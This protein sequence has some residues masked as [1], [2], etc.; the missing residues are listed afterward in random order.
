[1]KSQELGVSKAL[2]EHYSKTVK[3][4]R[5]SRYLNIF[6]TLTFSRDFIDNLDMILLNF[7]GVSKKRLFSSLSFE[8]YEK[9]GFEKALPFWFN[10]HSLANIAE[11]IVAKFE[12]QI[13]HFYTQ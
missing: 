12:I 4:V 2:Q 3:K 11:W 7:Y 8:G 13:I 1:M 10:V 9:N 6:D 5:I